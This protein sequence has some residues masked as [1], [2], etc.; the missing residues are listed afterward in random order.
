MRYTALDFETANNYRHSICAAGITILDGDKPVYTNNWLIKPHANQGFAKH[1][2][3][4]HGITREA[5]ENAQEFDKVYSLIKS[6]IS[7]KIIIAHNAS[8]DVDALTHTLSLYNIPI[9]EFEYLCSLRM[10]RAVWPKLSAYNL[11]EIC[12]FLNIELNHHEAGSDS[13]GCAEIISRIM[14]EKHE[15][16]LRR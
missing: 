3:E 11:H 6:H 2:I 12:S 10:A 14:E 9:P 13:R 7:G 1:N 15:T 5:V 4:I 16:D 8:F